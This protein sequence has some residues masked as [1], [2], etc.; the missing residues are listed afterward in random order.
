MPDDGVP[1]REHFEAVLAERDIRYQQRFEAQTKAIDAALSSAEKAVTKAETATERRFE[2]VNEFRQTLSD[3]AA[4][5]ISRV[6]YAALEKRVT[7][8]ATKQEKDTSRG[9]GIGLSAKF[10]VGAL[11]AAV[12]VIAI[13]VAAA[14]YLS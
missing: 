3:Q 11:T 4:T 12:A 14:N 10:V 9:E 8:L 7:E 2:G 6:E 5:F 1:L 13:V